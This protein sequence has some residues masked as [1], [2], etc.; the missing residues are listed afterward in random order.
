MTNPLNLVLSS[1]TES[2]LHSRINLLIQ[3]DSNK[4]I[5]ILLDYLYNQL[6]AICIA[7]FLHES[8][9][10]FI[11]KTYSYIAS[12]HILIPSNMATCRYAWYVQL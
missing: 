7:V 3:L 12:E 1:E 2:T 8:S 9:L 11:A 5:I 6:V 10:E 4:I